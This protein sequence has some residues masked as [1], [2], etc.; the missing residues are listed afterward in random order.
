VSS[1]TQILIDAVPTFNGIAVA[2]ETFDEH[3][4][5]RFLGPDGTPLPPDVSVGDAGEL[6]TQFDAALLPS[7]VDDT[8]YVAYTH[9]DPTGDLDVRFQM[10]SP[11]GSKSNAIGV[12]GPGNL[13]NLPNMAKLRDGSLIMV[14]QEHQ[15][16]TIEHLLNSGTVDGF[17]TIQDTEGA[18]APKV[19]ALKDSSFIVAWT[20]GVGTESDGSSNEDIFL[21]RFVITAPAIPQ[22]SGST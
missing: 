11:N 22:S 2:Y 16:I 13:A 9:R 8:V 21:R 20:A 10:V 17:A 1:A 15:G 14:W 18:Y 7:D 6:G 5:V 19:T 4:N 12:S 3:I